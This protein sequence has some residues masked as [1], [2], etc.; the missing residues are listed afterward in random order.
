MEKEI[1]EIPSIKTSIKSII[2]SNKNIEEMLKKVT[3]NTKFVEEEIFIDVKYVEK[4]IENTMIIDSGAPVSLMSSMWFNNYIKEAKVDNEQIK[5]SSSNRRFRLGKTPYIS[6][7]KVT[8]PIVVKADDNDFIKRNVTANII[9]SNE[10]NFL[11]GEETLVDWKTVLDFAERK[12]GFKEEN[13]TVELIKTSHLII[14]LELVGKW[15]DEDAVFL[16]QEED[17]V[18]TLKAVTKI[19]KVLNHKQKD[20]MLYAFRNAGNW[21]E[22]RES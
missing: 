18:K 12:L 5:K 15:R 11:C 20:Q 7:E 9:E 8:F 13:K 6:T 16:V 21:M 10:V 14:K 1:K 3:I 2:A 17:D 19:H 4:E 22:T